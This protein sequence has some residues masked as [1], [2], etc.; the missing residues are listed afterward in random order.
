MELHLRYFVAVAEM[1]SVT[2]AA[3]RRLYISQPSLNRQIRDLES[4]VGV[5]L[6]SRSVRGI[7]LTP[8]AR[9]FSTTPASC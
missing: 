2:E 3:E 6:L 1:G 4:R 5:R 8:A 9:L 7:E